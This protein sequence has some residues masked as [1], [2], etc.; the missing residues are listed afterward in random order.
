[1][2]Y[3]QTDNS[4]ITRP[5][6]LLQSEDALSIAELDSTLS[7]DQKLA[8][9]L[10]GENTISEDLLKLLKSYNDSLVII[11][12][13]E[14]PSKITDELFVIF[15]RPEDLEVINL[16][17]ATLEDSVPFRFFK[18]HKPK[19]LKI[20]DDITFKDSIFYT[21]WKQSG[22]LPDFI[23]PNRSSLKKVDSLI[24]SIP[25]VG[26]VYGVVKTED[27][28]LINEVRFKNYNDACVNGHFSFPILPGETLPILIPYKA[29]YQFSPDII[30]TTPENYRNS[31]TFIAFPLDI[32]Y[33]LSDHY[34]FDPRFI[35]KMKEHDKELLINN[36]VTVS[37]DIHGK[38]GYFNNRSYIDTGIESKSTFKENFTIAAWVKPTELGLNNSILG[39]G[40]NFVV[41]LRNGFLTFTMA[42]IMD[43]ISEASEVPLNKWSHIAITHSK[44]DHK[45]SFYVNGKLTEEV[46]L[47]AEYQ[48]SDFNIIIGSNLWEEFFKGYLADIKIWER[49]LN[50]TEVLTLFQNRDIGHT[51]DRMDVV[52]II[53]SILIVLIIGIVLW[54][55]HLQKNKSVLQSSHQK[56][57]KKPD[58]KRVV[59]DNEDA[60]RI[61]CFGKLRIFN[62]Y[63]ENLAEKLS[64][65]LK[66]IFIIVFLHSYRESQQ[67][68]S[69]KQLTEFLW[70]GMS[71]QKAKNTR[72][73]NINNLRTLLNSCQ[74]INLV[75][76]DNVWLI[77]LND[78]CYCD[79]LVVQYYLQVFSSEAYTIKTLEEALPKFIHILKGG[80]LFS[81]SSEAWLDSFIEKFSNQIIEQ[82]LEFTEVLDV[83]KHGE[84][85]FE[86]TEVISLYDDL[87]ERGHQIK[88]LTLIKQGKL[89]LAYKAHD[90]FKKLYYK[91]YKEDYPITFEDITSEQN[92]E[93]S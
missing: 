25:E 70:P 24:N 23:E 28:Q 83:N 50:G 15:K 27:G 42:G 20:E 44:I 16:N 81:D 33:E 30:Y 32:T 67:G 22:K 36:V 43:Y 26:Y 2:C 41:K 1:M 17:R 57:Y 91:I 5:Y 11:S 52:V 9:T 75:F 65:L 63:N 47:V 58:F 73:T 7:R 62:S 51:H 78:T 14:V 13:N 56:S 84:L 80:R 66:K 34:V 76:K 61:L 46:S 79:Y 82:C 4:Q 40:D 21:I 35:N 54:R 3:A 19:V 37:D 68:I 55:R 6:I 89:S 86:L 29:G 88:L 31:K 87:N 69:T 85:L 77:E 72:G 64:P 18:T 92:S 48:P 60:E 49:E 53:L 10:S 8:I 59:S 90:S 93:K 45:L 38:V 39:K 74:G 12:E 71:P